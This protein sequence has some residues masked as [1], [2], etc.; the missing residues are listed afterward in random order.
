M[1]SDFK[2][3]GRTAYLTSNYMIFD[4]QHLYTRSASSRVDSRNKAVEEHVNQTSFIQQKQ[5][6]ANVR[7]SVCLQLEK[8]C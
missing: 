6:R 7:E 1:L 2:F 5:H 4:R 3:F 8:V